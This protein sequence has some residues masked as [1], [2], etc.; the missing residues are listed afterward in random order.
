[1]GIA[2]KQRVTITTAW[3]N[4]VVFRYLRIHWKIHLAGSED[5]GQIRYFPIDEKIRRDAPHDQNEFSRGS[6]TASG[7]S[8]SASK[9]SDRALMPLPLARV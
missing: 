6:A 9:L 5:R 3:L 7:M 2:Q 1:M 8:S 4:T